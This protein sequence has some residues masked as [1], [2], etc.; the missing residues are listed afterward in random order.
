MS[1]AI[2]KTGGKQYRVSQGDL[3]EVELLPLEEGSTA[4]F[5]DVLFLGGNG[6][7]QVGTPF[8]SGAKVTAKVVGQ[9]RAKKVTAFK[10]KRRTGY[11]L[12]KGHR[13][14]LTRLQIESI[15]A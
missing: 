12:T 15:G 5:D 9:V 7:V 4:V 8:V 2:F 1:Y 6:D 13:R 11:H 10:Y 14:Q 3:V